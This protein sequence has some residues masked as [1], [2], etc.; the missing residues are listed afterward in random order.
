MYVRTRYSR[1][2][3]HSSASVRIYISFYQQ[4]L[5]YAPSAYVQLIHYYRLYT[6]RRVQPRADVR[7]REK[8]TVP[9][10]DTGCST[11]VRSFSRM[12]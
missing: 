11:F 4:Y 1:R 5:T 3:D 10:D 2:R 7:E 12:A 9:D 6:L 8:Y